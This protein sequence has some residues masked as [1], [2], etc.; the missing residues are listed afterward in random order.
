MQW[1]LWIPVLNVNLFYQLNS[2]RQVLATMAQMS[3]S[4]PLTQSAT[5]CASEQQTLLCAVWHVTG[6]AT[7]IG[8]MRVMTAVVRHASRS[9]IQLS[10]RYLEAE[11]MLCNP[12]N[13]PQP[14]GIISRTTAILPDP[15]RASKMSQNISA[16]PFTSARLLAGSVML[17]TF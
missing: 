9:A 13:T 5:C 12:Q 7:T 11:V 1:L 3:C 4:V 10:K 6:C 14:K 16:T 8:L 15:Y 17:L 2:L